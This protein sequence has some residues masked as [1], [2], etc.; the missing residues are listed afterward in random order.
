MEFYWAT[1]AFMER[2]FVKVQDIC[3]FIAWGAQNPFFFFF[4]PRRFMRRINTQLEQPF[5]SAF[6]LVEN[7]FVTLIGLFSMHSA[8]SRAATTLTY[9]LD[10]MRARLA[11]HK[12]SGLVDGMRQTY[13][14]GMVPARFH[15][16]NTVWLSI[17]ARSLAKKAIW[18][19]HFTV[20]VHDFTN[21]ISPF[22]LAQPN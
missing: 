4:L 12:H 19:G 16:S 5:P 20:R 10:L 18:L 15:W 11:M 3:R 8:V 13:S 2:F 21:Q 1:F 17:L 22:F 6:R 7:C 14:L 9:P